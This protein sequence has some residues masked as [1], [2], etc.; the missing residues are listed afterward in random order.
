MLNK[1]YFIILIKAKSNKLYTNFKY[2]IIN[3]LDNIT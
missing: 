3:I 2:T 1:A